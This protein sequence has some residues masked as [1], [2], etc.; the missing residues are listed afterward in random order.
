MGVVAA[1]LTELQECDFD[2]DVGLGGVHNKCPGK[3]EKQREKIRKATRIMSQGKGISSAST[4]SPF[5]RAFRAA[6]SAD[7]SDGTQS[8][9]S[10][11]RKLVRRSSR[12]KK[13]PI[14][15]SVASTNA[16]RFSSS[17]KPPPP[18]KPKHLIKKQNSGIENNQL[19]HQQM[20]SDIIPKRPSSSSTPSSSRSSPNKTVNKKTSLSST[21]NPLLSKLRRRSDGFGSLILKRHQFFSQFSQDNSSSSASKENPKVLNKTV[22]ERQF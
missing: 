4:D 16:R 5:S 6:T 9:S 20:R 18:P 12:V 22:K 14:L 2:D 15:P 1:S 3:A 10:L 7:A 11:H 21:P 13:R 8:S 17:N 19:Q